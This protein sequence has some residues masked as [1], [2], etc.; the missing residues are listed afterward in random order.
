MK[1]RIGCFIILAMLG[2]LLLA[3][4]SAEPAVAEEPVWTTKLTVRFATV[5]EGQQ[6]MR[7]RTRFHD[8]ITESTLDFYLQRKGGTL[9]DYIGYSADQVME[10]TPEEEKRVNDTLTWLQYTLEHHGL[11]LPDPGEITFVKSTCQEVLGAAGY[12][13]GSAIFF[14]W[15]MY[16]PEYCTDDLFRQ[17]VVHEIFH[18][19]SR[20]YPEFRQAMYSLIHFTILDHEI[21]VPE[22]IREWIIA[23]P[24]VEHHD[25][26]ATFTIGGEKKDCYLVFL[27]DSVFE[28][29]GDTLFEGMYSGIVPLDG[30]AVYRTD[31]VEDF[32]DVVGRNTDYVEDP[33]EA[34]ASNFAF[35]IQN[36]DAGYEQ[37][38][39]PGI[40]EG[41][42]E[43]LEK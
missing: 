13:S 2:T 24:D 35:A 14:C 36:L 15:F 31:E 28:K 17:V 26:Y 18:C 32:W 11:L 21:E 22:E 41:I 23:N 9:E 33:E 34:M 12:T 29:E 7:E 16:S 6:L 10:F 38:P 43:Y 42:V 1:K 27:T 25:S 3:G 20:K 37:F 8:Q 4:C 40:L 39:S 30:S 19:L 5:E